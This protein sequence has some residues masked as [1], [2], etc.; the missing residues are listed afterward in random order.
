[1]YRRVVML[2]QVAKY[3]VIDAQILRFTQ[4]DSLLL[5]SYRIIGVV[6]ICK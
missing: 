1:M 6:V 2:S 3:L 5:M 4:N